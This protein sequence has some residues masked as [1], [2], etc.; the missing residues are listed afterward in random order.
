M[1]TS[2]ARRKVEFEERVEPALAATA[3]AGPAEIHA[4]AART[5]AP[6]DMHPGVYKVALLCWAAF[7]GIFWLT[8]WFSANA[9]FQVVISTFYATMFFG[10]P[11]V[12][13]R[14]VR[15]HTPQ[16]RLGE[17]SDFLRGR[18]DT[19]DG[20]ISAFDA[21]MQVILVPFL[22]TGGGMMIGFIIHSARLAH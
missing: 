15:A 6:A 1:P 2:Q 5:V 8:F 22:L 4:L 12:L 21:L 3:Q 20:P 19:I 17:F 11:F 16:R 10:V 9:L 13:N 14:I 7:L 18:F